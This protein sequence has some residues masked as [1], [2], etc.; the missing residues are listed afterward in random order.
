[1]R[2]LLSILLKIIAAV[3]LLAGVFLGYA[4]Y[5]VHSRMAKTYAVTT[6][7]LDIKSDAALVE[8]GRYLTSHVIVC[9]DCHGQNL[10]G[11]SMSDDVMFGRL[12]APNL[13]SGRG[14][15]ASRYD[16]QDFARVLLHGRPEG[17]PLRGLHAVAGLQADRPRRGGRHHLPA[18]AAAC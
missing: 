2:R 13:T 11:G 3:L 14:G 6:P 8:R 10:G 15:I 1:M 12:Y 9:A 18:F 17:R 5:N 16:D 7:P 4:C